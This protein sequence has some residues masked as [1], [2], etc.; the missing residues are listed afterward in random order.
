M[1]MIDLNGMIEF[2]HLAVSR[3]FFEVGRE[4]RGLFR[5]IDTI[6]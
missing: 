4:T 5:I 6:H 2:I 1:L 3:R